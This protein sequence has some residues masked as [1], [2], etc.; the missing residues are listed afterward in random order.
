MPRTNRLPRHADAWL[1]AYHA[2]MAP[3]FKRADAAIALT[4]RLLG[5][6]DDGRC[7]WCE[8]GGAHADGCLVM[9]WAG[10]A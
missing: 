4:R 7:D 2:E 10:E 8:Q 3:L 9:H 6:T 5:S 1:A